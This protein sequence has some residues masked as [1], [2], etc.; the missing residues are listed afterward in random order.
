[1]IINESVVV[2]ADVLP[3][4]TLRILLTRTKGLLNHQ[5]GNFKYLIGL[6]VGVV[7]LGSPLDGFGMAWLTRLIAWI[8]SPGDSHSGIIQQLGY[9]NTSLRDTLIG[10]Q[11]LSK[12]I[13]ILC[14]CFYE[15]KC[16]DY[17]TKYGPFN[18]ISTKDKL[19]AEYLKLMSLM[20]EKEIPRDFLH[21]TYDDKTSEAG[22]DS[23]AKTEWP[24]IEVDDVHVEK[25]IGTLAAYAFITKTATED[26]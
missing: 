12:E 16:T 22:E 18:Q 25:S 4:F 14:Y 3:K 19:A 6:T 1:M 10:F 9:G 20:L 26:L 2:P 17:G 7:L 21:A 23:K 11:R 8:M 5:N 24:P 15:R 13:S